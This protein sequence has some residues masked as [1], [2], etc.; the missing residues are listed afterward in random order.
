M[1]LKSA[2]LALALLTAGCSGTPLPTTTA[3]LQV[4]S[5]SSLPAPT[6]QDVY[7]L[8]GQ[9]FAIAP[10]DRL[11]IDVYGLN[12]LSNRVVQVDASGNI[13]FP[14]AG[15]LSVL[16]KTPEQV[17]TIIADALR[18]NY[19]RDPQV[20]V[21]L[22]QAT[23]R[24]V[25]VY[26]EVREP[27]VYPVTGR[28]TLMRAIASARGLG[29]FASEDEVVIFRNVGGQSLAAIYSMDA[30]RAGT[31]ADPEIYPNDVVAVGDSPSRRLFRELINSAS[32]LTTPLVLLLQNNN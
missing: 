1:K 24:G 29:E 21:N 17:S 14:F 30:I 32:L 11:R 16:G 8:T 13:A 2:S 20:T 3:D 6:T 7:G 19:I 15:T 23:Q 26:G 12:D 25:T 10:L 31:Y 22:D 5:A 18:A 9:S 28:M 4:V 27:G